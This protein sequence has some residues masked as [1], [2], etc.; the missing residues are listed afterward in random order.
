[1]VHVAPQGIFLQSTHNPT[2]QEISF[3]LKHVRKIFSSQ[4]SKHIAEMQVSSTSY[5][6][7]LDVH[8]IG[9]DHKTWSQ[10]TT[11]LFKEGLKL[12][13]A[14]QGLAKC[15]KN[16]PRIMHNSCCSDTCTVWV[17]IHDMVSGSYAKG[18]IGQFIPIASV[19][20][21]IAGAKPH[22]G[23]LQCTWCLK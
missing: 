9:N 4:D 7:V 21:H 17:D 6:K 3:V 16:S 19:N 22:A 23:L 5:L 12:S 14:G 15:I 8:A 18:L 20:C 2:P 10:E 13:P 1:L 11:E